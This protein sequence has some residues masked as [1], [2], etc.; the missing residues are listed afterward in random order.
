MAT[1]DIIKA[2]NKETAERI[3]TINSVT[4]QVGR[5]RTEVN[6]KIGDVDSSSKNVSKITNKNLAKINRDMGKIKK[7][8]HQQNSDIRAMSHQKGVKEVQSSLNVVMRSLSKSVDYMAKGVQRTSLDAAKVTQDAIGQYGKAIS[9]DISINK[10]NTVAMA[11]ARSTPLFG[12]FASKFMETDIYS[13]F[14]DK[15]KGKFTNVA[16]E[17]GFSLKGIARHSFEKIKDLRYIGRKQ[18]LMDLYSDEDESLGKKAIKEKSKYKAATIEEK[19]GEASEKHTIPHL[20]EGGIVKKS[21]LAK[22]HKGEVVTSVSDLLDELDNRVEKRGVE[23]ES[24]KEKI[25]NAISILTERSIQAET[26]VGRYEKSRSTIMKDFVKSYSKARNEENFSMQQ[27]QLKAIL[28][29]KVS[30][31]GM[32]SR[33]RMAWQETLIK[34]PTFRN[35]LSFSRILKTTFEFP[36]RF[37]FTATGGYM[38]EIKKITRSKNVF[39]NILSALCLMYAKWSPKFDSMKLNLIDLAD[40]LVGEKKGG[41]EA[42]EKLT[43]RW[44][45]LKDY[46]KRAKKHGMAKSLF[47]AGRE[48]EG[49]IGGMFGTYARSLGLDQEALKEAGIGSFG[50]AFDFKGLMKKS[51]MGEVLKNVKEK[52]KKK[53]D[54]AK[55]KLRELFG[56]KKKKAPKM[57]DGGAILK[58]G[59]INA[60]KGEF[61]VSNKYISSFIESMKS[62]QKYVVLLGSSIIN[63]FK[64]SDEKREEISAKAVTASKKTFKVLSI[65]TWPIKKIAKIL[66]RFTKFATRMLTKI[67]KKL[68]TWGWK[69]MMFGFTAIKTMFGGT[70]KLGWKALLALPA[71]LGP[72]VSFLPIIAAGMGLKWAVSDTKKAM[73]KSGEWGV[74]KWQAGIGGFLGG[75]QERKTRTDVVKSAA[76]GAAKGA[77]IGAGIGS[78]VPGFGTVIGGAIGALAGGLLGAIGGQNISKGIKV[79]SKEIVILSKAVFSF[80]TWPLRMVWKIIK[81]AK[82]KMMNNPVMKWIGK[83]LGKDAPRMDD[84][85]VSSA[86]STM[87]SESPTERNKWH[88]VNKAELARHQADAEA[89]RINGITGPLLKSSHQM[90][91]QIEKGNAATVAQIQYN[92]SAIQ[93]TQNTSTN[94]GG[95]SVPGAPTDE[96][97][98]RIIEGDLS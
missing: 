50:S 74:K 84:D 60:H 3:K 23:D 90:K 67:T 73:A 28:E 19:A 2:A 29:L 17:I 42:K 53:S 58:S 89:R 15:I 88:S 83:K 8:M 33:L 7:D 76:K 12:Y 10:Q 92:T 20:A 40:G 38:S 61:V 6:K 71:L 4:G 26:Y 37:L 82:A 1:E 45:G 94:M 66:F 44:E 51:G 5:L 78:I 46:A 31:V 59:L 54:E 49:D 9:E 72:L 25:G 68:G 21:G 75:A 48:K 97:T 52:R 70:L 98:R 56:F 95:G 34:H 14:A 65:I 22:I 81:F 69:I 55:E 79:I 64:I 86:M 41:R 57:A 11:L 96:N 30:L 13:G 32:T 87:F 77:A 36:M 93:N 62:F 80:V 24:L 18:K 27:R 47:G 16:K 39:S 43:T 91:E 63:R 35:I 85:I